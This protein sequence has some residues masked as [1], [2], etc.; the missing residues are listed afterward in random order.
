MEIPCPFNVKRLPSK[1]KKPHAYVS[2][3]LSYTKPKRYFSIRAFKSVVV[4]I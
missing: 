4:E 3:G 2:M 1:Y